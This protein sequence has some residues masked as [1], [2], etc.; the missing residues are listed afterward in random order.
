MQINTN[1]GTNG[2]LLQVFGND[3]LGMTRTRTGGP[4]LLIDQ[5]G[6]ARLPLPVLLEAS[7]SGGSGGSGK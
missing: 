3:A 2:R 7:D 6:N 5:R 4:Y 1:T